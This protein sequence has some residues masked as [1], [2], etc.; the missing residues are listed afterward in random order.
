LRLSSGIK[1][2]TIFDLVIKT[3]PM[4]RIL[5]ITI[6]LLLAASLTA[7]TKNAE[8]KNV[9]AT[10][11]SSSRLFS[12][13][14]DMTSVVIIIPTGSTVKVLD[15]DSTYMHVTFEEN[16]GYI[17]SKTAII[18]KTPVNIAQMI[19]DQPQTSAP[20]TTKEQPL[21]RFSYLEKKY[22]TTMATRLYSGKIW[23]GMNSEMVKD[24]WGSAQKINRTINGNT[25]QEEWLYKTTWLY[26]ENNTLMDWG[27]VKQ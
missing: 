6:F 12:V 16:E 19:Q 1:V 4:K 15:S 20:Q 26:F 22:G 13:K 14:D 5:S 8:N 23:K 3:I 7:Q 18:D 27:P 11:K 17:F 24:S 2:G 10:L 25:V 9:T 21:S